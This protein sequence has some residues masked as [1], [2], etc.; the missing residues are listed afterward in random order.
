[1]TMTKFLMFFVAFSFLV[2]INAQAQSKKEAEVQIQ[3]SAQCG[4]CKDRIEEALSFT[5]GVTFAELNL[6][7]KIVT[8]H[9]KTKKTDIE[10]IKK[11]ITETGYDADEVAAEPKAYNKL[12][13][14]CQKGGHDGMD[15]KENHKD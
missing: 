7:T 10:A 4:M 12:P 1:M 2:V 11:A 14:C 15:M 8:V 3:T 5:K 9:Y 13:K 6:D